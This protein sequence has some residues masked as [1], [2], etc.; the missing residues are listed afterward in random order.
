MRKSRFLFL[1][2]L[3]LLA[4]L[5]LVF[6][7]CSYITG[8]ALT[9]S[10]QPRIPQ[11]FIK[12][13]SSTEAYAIIALNA[14]HANFTIIDVRTPEEYANGHI[15]AALNR[16]YNSPTF[17]NDIAKFDKNKIYVVYC[18]S[19]VRSA[20]ARDIMQEL[21]FQQIYNMDGG[22]TAWMAQGLPVVK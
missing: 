20:G 5:S 15:K 1:S 8:E 14:G 6:N 21:G 2:I 7:S 17:K 13:V 3:V 10:F 19:G 4:A 16:D 12:N 18:Q 9:E 22:I 11:E